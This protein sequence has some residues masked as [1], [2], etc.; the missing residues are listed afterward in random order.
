MHPSLFVSE[1]KTINL[2][3]SQLFCKQTIPTRPHLWTDSSHICVICLYELY[4][5]DFRQHKPSM[6]AFQCLPPSAVA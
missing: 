3:V 1:I 4:T 2:G 5:H 6:I